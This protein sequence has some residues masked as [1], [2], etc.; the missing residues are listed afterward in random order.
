MIPLGAQY[1]EI[2]RRYLLAQGITVLAQNIR[3]THGE[4][5]IIGLEKPQ[6]Y[7]FI[8]V[9]GRKNINYGAPA[10]F[11]DYRKQ[12]KIIQAA[13]TYLAEHRLDNVA[14]RF[15][16]ISI[17]GTPD[18]T[19]IQTKWWQTKPINNEVQIEWLTN[20]FEL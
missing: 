9:K 19:K 18:I 1:E 2:A 10:D 7:L 4:I 11:V 5:D 3:Y 6:T 17:S 14:C 12:Q 8:E 20:A 13:Q 16:V 15:D